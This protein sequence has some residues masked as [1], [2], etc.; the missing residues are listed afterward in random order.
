MTIAQNPERLMKDQGVQVTLFAMPKRRK[1][2]TRKIVDAVSESDKENEG[3]AGR[4]KRRRNTKKSGEKRDV[5]GNILNA[6]KG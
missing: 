3:I 1:R 5:L 2:A 6:T 4:V